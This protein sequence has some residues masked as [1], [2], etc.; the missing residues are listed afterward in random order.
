MLG[1]P[2]GGLCAVKRGAGQAGE[3]SDE[4]HVG[5]GEGGTAPLVV[6]HQR[7]QHFALAAERRAHRA[8]GPVPPDHFHSW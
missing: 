5:L 6:G 4:R 2:S 3:C 8:A 7:A 1:R